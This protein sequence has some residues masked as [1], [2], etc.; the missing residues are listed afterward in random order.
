MKQPFARR[1]W[2][3]S[4]WPSNKLLIL[5]SEK[6]DAKRCLNAAQTRLNQAQTQLAQARKNAQVKT[7]QYT[8]IGSVY[9]DISSGRRLALARWIAS[10]DN[11]LSARVA[12]NHVWLRHIGTALVPSVQNFGRNG[13]LPSHPELLDWLAVEFMQPID[14]AKRSSA[15]WSFKL[16][17]PPDCHQQH[18]SHGEY[19]R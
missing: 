4:C 14:S 17:A 8:P 19:R 2:S 10:R 7:N 13:K 5:Q 15:A 9:P 6:K 11:P 3:L 12:V 18:L 16:H 1:N